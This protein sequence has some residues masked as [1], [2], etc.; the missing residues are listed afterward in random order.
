[1]VAQYSYWIYDIIMMNMLLE[2]R[3]FGTHWMASALWLSTSE[4]NL[5]KNNATYVHINTDSCALRSL[6]H[7]VMTLNNIDSM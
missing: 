1:M 3:V 2:G 4:W 6:L 7:H 5:E